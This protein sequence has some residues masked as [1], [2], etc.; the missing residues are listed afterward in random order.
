MPAPARTPP[1]LSTLIVLTGLSVLTLN[2]FMP[3]LPSIAEDFGADYAIVNLSI[4]GYLALTGVLQLILGPMSDRYGRRP[5][6]LVGLAIFVVASLGCALSTSVWMFLAFRMLQGVI[7]A[8]S[9]LSRAV[10]RDTTEPNQAASLMGYVGMIMAIAPMTGPMFGGLLEQFFGWRSTFVFF[11]GGG[12]MVLIWCWIDLGE[13]NT[14]PSATFAA[15]FRSYPE[16]LRSRR[17]WGYTLCVSFSVGAFYAFLGGAPLASKAHFNLS[18]AAL[19][20]GLGSITSGFMLGNYLSGRLTPRYGLT[21]MMIAGRVVASAALLI[22]LC[23]WMAGVHHVLVLFAPAVA[24]GLGNGL[25]MPSAHA[26]TM[27]VRPHLAG[28]AS[29]LSGAVMVMGGALITWATAALLTD[30]NAAY[31]VL[32][33]MLV[34]AGGGLAAALYVRRIDLREGPP[35]AQATSRDNRS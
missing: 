29:G 14:S 8:G 20:I 12:L 22:G 32:G 16:L 27:S 13:T 10:I 28:S 26:G 4:A 18:P 3:S 19:G 33:M 31:G 21:M 25:T 9:V 11:T 1:R 7:I 6:L 5:V 17:F 15:Q 23:L 35:D 34:S 24:T 30:S 2:M